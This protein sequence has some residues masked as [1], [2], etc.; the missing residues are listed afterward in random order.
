MPKIHFLWSNGDLAYCNT[1]TIL[2]KSISVQEFYCRYWRGS[3][4]GSPRGASPWLGEGVLQWW[5]HANLFQ[6]NCYASRDIELHVE[7]EDFD[8]I[9]LPLE[10]TFLADW[11]MDSYSIAGSN[12][13]HLKSYLNYKIAGLLHVDHIYIYFV[14]FI[15]FIGSLN[16]ERSDESMFNCYVYCWLTFICKLVGHKVQKKMCCLYLK[17][18]HCPATSD[19]EM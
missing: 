2:F 11:N 5:N 7:I 19:G 15:S 18:N 10:Y 14:D 9:Q 4:I 13:I 12:S 3:N 17:W 6:R 1:A 16:G 8:T